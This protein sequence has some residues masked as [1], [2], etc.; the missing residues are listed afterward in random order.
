MEKVQDIIDA[1]RHD[2]ASIDQSTSLNNMIDERI[3]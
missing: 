3:R 1:S 2:M